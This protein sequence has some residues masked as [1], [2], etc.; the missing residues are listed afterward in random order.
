MQWNELKMHLR[1]ISSKD[2]KRIQHAFELGKQVHE[3]Q[4]R[5]SGEPYFMHPI[6]VMHMLAD[7]GADADTL[8]AA[9]LHDTVEDTDLTLTE[10]DKQFEGDV[11]ALIDGVT[12]LEPEDVA[13]VPT[14]NDQ[15]E[16]LRKMFTLIEEDARII[17]IKLVDRLHNMQTVEHLGEERQKAMAQETMDVYVKIADRLSMQDI[18]DELEGLCLNVLN[19]E[20]LVTLSK[21]RERNEG[22]TLKV[23]TQ[24]EKELS[25]ANTKLFQEVELQYEPKSWSKLKIQMQTTQAKTGVADV[26]IS[27]ICR[28]YNDC[29]TT[30]G[31]L[32]QLWPRETLSFQDFINSPMINGYRGLHTTIILENGTRVRCKIRTEEMDAYAHLGI[33]TICFDNEQIGLTEYLIPWTKQIS[34]VAA[35]TA[36]DSDEFWETL[37]NDILGESIVIHGPDDSRIIL[38]A[39]STALDGAFYFLRERALKLKTISLD[40]VMV[41]YRT[42]LTHASSLSCSTGKIK[43]VK[44]EWLDWVNSGVAVAHIR[45]A[46]KQESKAVREAIGKEMLQSIFTKQKKGYIEEFNAG[47][48][49]AATKSLGYPSMTEAYLALAD[50]HLNPEDIFEGVFNSSK[51]IRGAEK[52]RE[53]CS[54]S[55]TLNFDNIEPVT[56]TLILYKKYGISLR[57]VRFRPLAM[58]RGHVNVVH[59]LSPK[60]QVAM[61]KD[62]QAVGALNVEIHKAG[63]RRK[64]WVGICL[65]LLLWGFDPA[66]ARRIIDEYSVSPIDLTLLRFW[67]LACISGL[68]V[69][70]KAFRNDIPQT[71]LPLCS[72]SLWLSVVLMI[73]VALLG[74]TALQTTDPI[75]Y[76][77]PM[78]AAGV[79]LTTI[80][81]RKHIFIMA[82]SW[83]LLIAGV[84]SAVIF[85]PAWPLQGIV[86]TF[87]TVISFSLF[88]ILSERY[89]RRELV[90]ARS[91]QYFFV[92]SLLAA[93]LTLPL[94]SFATIPSL[95]A[96]AITNILLFSIFFAGLP[97]YMYYYF[98][99]Y[100]QIDFVL[101]YSF[102]IMFTTLLGQMLFSKH[103]TPP[104]TNVLLSMGVVTIGAA[105]PIACKKLQCMR[106]T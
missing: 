20:L 79:L 50:G 9:L 48:L 16:T 98:L 37:Q 56:N 26:V 87:L 19:P 93:I 28:N 61:L 30:L 13:G 51:K 15:I 46:L 29:Y 94:A 80:V 71:R 38:P 44:R 91:A 88:S 105:L 101:R 45:N 39:G 47:T 64:F 89:K 33:A 3:G 35:D 68:L 23:I 41:N 5:K 49:E 102:I 104:S 40:G 42:P 95:S 103:I 18:R 8:I 58:M 69:L 6:A 2:L 25:A 7:I 12:K 78:T 82:C 97:Y 14:L 31:Y 81:N 10:I 21:L 62:L 100:K 57:N 65:L 73:M 32:H 27:V 11:A 1:H 86:T 77:I 74:Y 92:L 4:K 90:G 60:E 106:N 43:T 55:F 59:S 72:I 54:I 63:T 34:H 70:W 66:I 83:V 96:T 24:M 67:G 75:Q 22:N 84:I 85:A 36:N 99:T 52:D 76:S 17:V 53:Q